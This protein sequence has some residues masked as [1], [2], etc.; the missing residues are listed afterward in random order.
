M[1]CMRPNR[2][3]KG[4]LYEQHLPQLEEIIAKYDPDGFWFD[5]D[6]GIERLQCWC[7]NCLAE[8]KA[9]T[10]LEA[11]VRPTRRIG[12]AG[13]N[14]TSRGTVPE[15]QSWRKRFAKRIPARWR[16]STGCGHG[17]PNRR[18]RSSMP[19]QETTSAASIPSSA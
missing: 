7:P 3:R 5:G 2:E 11:P 19:S 15:S 4:Y 18:R 9:D 6:I 17:R 8:W 12:N 16:C 1:I 13:W 14:G 10:G